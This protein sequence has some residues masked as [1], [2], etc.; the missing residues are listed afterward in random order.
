MDFFAGLPLF[1][2]QIKAIARLA[3]FQS[4]LRT[5]IIGDRFATKSF[6][7]LKEEL[8]QLQA[9]YIA[10]SFNN[11][12]FKIRSWMEGTLKEAVAENKVVIITDCHDAFGNNDPR[13]LKLTEILNMNIDVITLWASIPT[14]LHSQLVFTKI[15]NVIRGP[16]TE[17]VEREI[18]A[19]F[20]LN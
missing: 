1:H 14:S 17:K 19:R 13:Q 3:A 16:V 8:E 2:S 18:K 9:P 4:K 7:V 12:D 10:Y 11:P 5:A 6:A 20:G 15:H